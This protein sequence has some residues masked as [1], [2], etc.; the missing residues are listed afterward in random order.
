VDLAFSQAAFFFQ[1]FQYLYHSLRRTPIVE[2]LFRLD[3]DPAEEFAVSPK[4]MDVPR[5]VIALPPDENVAATPNFSHC[6]NCTVLHTSTASI[7][8]GKKFVT[9]RD[10]PGFPEITL[11]SD[12]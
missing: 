2:R 1:F 6:L 12:F 10:A 7:E 8:I 9:A 5:R 4:N 3:R 11:T